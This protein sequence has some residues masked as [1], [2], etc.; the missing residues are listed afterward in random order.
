MIVDNFTLSGDSISTVILTFT[1]TSKKWKIL[2][3]SLELYEVVKYE[4]DISEFTN[5][6]NRYRVN[7]TKIIQGSCSSPYG[8][9]EIELIQ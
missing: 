8:I 9:E 4:F 6:E 3:D 1:D 5:K 2:L 7:G